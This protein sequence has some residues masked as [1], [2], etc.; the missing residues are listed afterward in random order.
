MKLTTKTILATLLVTAI[1]GCSPKGA[2][3]QSASK[4][5]TAAQ[6]QKLELNQ[7]YQKAVE[8][9]GSFS[10][11]QTMAVNPVVVFFDPQCPHCRALWTASQ[12]V[13]NQHK[14][15]WI[16]VAALGP[17]SSLQGQEIIADKSKSI[18]KMNLHESLAAANKGGISTANAS[19]ELEALIQENTNLFEAGRFQS[20]PF[21][22]FKKKDG[23]LGSFS[24]APDSKQLSA[25]LA[26]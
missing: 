6:T 19:K 16:P 21:V 26:N 1:A 14:F 3:S 2:D 9:Q 12:G 5:T 25:V 24:G 4:N 13:L 18:E 23:S 22:I 8:L 10:V 20:V 15:L 11:G 17:K 7:V